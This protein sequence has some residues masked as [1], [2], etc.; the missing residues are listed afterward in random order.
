M[1][2]ATVCVAHGGRAPQVKAAAA[3]RLEQQAAIAAMAAYGLPRKVDPADALL[4][5]VHRTAGHVA[6]LQERVAGLD[7][8]DLVWGT[9][10]E[11]DKGSGTD[12]TQAA[13]PS[14]WLELYRG[15]RK[16]LAE[17]CKTAL[18]AGVAERQIRLAEQQ[19][20][21]L[22]GVIARV[23]DGLD[24]SAEQQARVAEV[25]PRE[26]RAVSQAA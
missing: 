6:W 1:K 22:A 20:A 11:V 5:E 25:V 24:L 4:E 2:G 13:K 10:Q 9:V 3:R 16:H 19:G 7:A 26:L 23:L 12:T 18:A 15:E 8:D 21:M 17:V 14:V